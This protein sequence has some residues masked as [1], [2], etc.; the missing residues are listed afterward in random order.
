MID[1]YLVV[2]SCFLAGVLTTLHPCPLTTNIASVTLLSGWSVKNKNT[3][4]T[5]VFFILGYIFSF[6]VLSIII[7]SGFLSI[8]LISLSLQTNISLLLGP[9]LILVGMI[10]CDLIQLQSLYKGRIFNHFKNKRYTGIQA[11]PFGSLIA[12]SFCPATAAIFFGLLIPLS[13]EYE[14]RFLFPLLY[15]FGASIPLII[16][17][18][19]IKKGF[20]RN[21]K[22]ALK[23][24]VHKIAGW[25]LIIMGI[26]ISIQRIYLS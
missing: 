12:L 11:F 6:L 3:G 16:I 23:T 2:G 10:L 18:I 14:Q 19:F 13:I 1:S 5:S 15:A 9:Y 26:Y 25:F 21:K 4:L 17:S 7:S 8:P 22:L 24:K 20:L